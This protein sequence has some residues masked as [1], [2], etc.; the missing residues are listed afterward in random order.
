MLFFTAD[1]GLIAGLTV[2]T[3]DLDEASI[4]LHQLAESVGGRCGFALGSMPPPP[5]AAEFEATAS[6]ETFLRLG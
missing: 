3:E 6:G 5:T 1:G 2:D 4:Y